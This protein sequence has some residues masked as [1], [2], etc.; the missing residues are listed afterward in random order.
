MKE[1]HGLTHIIGDSKKG[2]PESSFFSPA[3]ISRP[4]SPP[5]E[6]EIIHELGLVA[7]SARDMVDNVIKCYESMGYSA[8][9][10][11]SLFTQV[12]ESQDKMISMYES[13]PEEKDSLIA[14]YGREAIN[15]DF[16]NT[17]LRSL[18][19]E[20]RRT[21]NIEK[22]STLQL[23]RL[24]MQNLPLHLRLEYRAI[25]LAQFGDITAELNEMEQ[26]PNNESILLCN[27]NSVLGGI[28][29][30]E[31]NEFKDVDLFALR[32]KSP[33]RG[34]S[35][36]RV[37]E[38]VTNHLIHTKQK[39]SSTVRP[40]LS[41]TLQYIDK[42]FYGK[43]F[44]GIEEYGTNTDSYIKFFYDPG[45]QNFIGHSLN[46]EEKKYIIDTYNTKDQRLLQIQFKGKKIFII[47]MSIVGYN[48]YSDERDDFVYSMI[49]ELFEKGCVITNLLNTKQDIYFILEDI[50]HSA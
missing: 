40:W 21:I 36:Q 45:F 38:H 7:H 44:A 1:M 50:S 14:Q 30:I 20:E 34:F 24:P 23:V 5:S 6:R 25:L 37:S 29:L 33:L 2:A 15:M 39:I 28:S 35:M 49:E 9:N 12:L 10:K 47:K 19:R 13:N 18:T 27:Y 11:V 31:K 8:P 17:F 43:G 16:T 4:D 3:N 48:A 32:K 26:N 46:T 41:E 22:L 42:G